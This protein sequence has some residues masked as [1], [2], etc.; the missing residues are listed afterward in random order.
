MSSARQVLCLSNQRQLHLGMALFE[1]EHDGALPILKLAHGTPLTLEGQQWDNSLRDPATNYTG[2]EDYRVVVNE[3][4]NAEVARRRNSNTWQWYQPSWEDGGVVIS[5]PGAVK[6]PRAH[7]Y[8]MEAESGGYDA[9]YRFGGFQMDYILLGMNQLYY[10]TGP[11]LCNKRSTSIATAPDE[12]PM[13]GEPCRLGS[14]AQGLNNHNGRGLN[15]VFFD[16]AGKW[17]HISDTVMGGYT[18]WSGSN[19][20][21]SPGIAEYRKASGWYAQVGGGFRIERPGGN[22]MGNG[23]MNPAYP[24]QVATH[25]K[26]IRKA[27]YAAINLGLR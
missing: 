2:H 14:T 24:N 3:Y 13:I 8:N 19:R 1:T 23:N 5:C 7:E 11:G 12:T 4:M 9:Y 17:V 16:G 26:Y 10:G 22:F 6:N 20:F 25:Q 18:W 27:G 15:V 21:G